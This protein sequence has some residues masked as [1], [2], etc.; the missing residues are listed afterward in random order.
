MGKKRYRLDCQRAEAF[1]LRPLA[2]IIAAG[3]VPSFLEDE[4]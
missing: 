4:K 1:D 2:W 3:G